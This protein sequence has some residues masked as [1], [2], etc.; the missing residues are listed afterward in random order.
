MTEDNYKQRGLR[1]KL[2]SKL[3]LKGITDEAV[4]SAIAKVPRHVFFEDALL[5]H[6]YEDKAFPI[7]EGQTISQ[8]YT[9]AFQTEKLQIKPGN[10][11]LEVGTGS[12]YQAAILLEMGATVYTIEFNRKLYEKTRDFLP[13]LGYRPYFFYGDGSKGI[14]I[15]APFDKII[16]T[17]GAPIIPQTLLNQLTEDGIMVIPVG[18]R[19][20][21]KMMRLIKK[22]EKVLKEEFNQFAFVPLLGAEGWNLSG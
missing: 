20:A 7:G 18:N 1:N 14:P 12:G 13:M 4:L 2:V 16:V 9:V 3:R 5:S 15:K 22:K 21:Q 17:A 8:P 10:K 6:A 11:V 19:D